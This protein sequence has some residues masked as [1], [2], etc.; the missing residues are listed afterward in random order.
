MPSECYWRTYYSASPRSAEVRD[1]SIPSVPSASPVAPPSFNIESSNHEG[2]QSDADKRQPAAVVT[3]EVP[4]ETEPQIVGQENGFPE[5]DSTAPQAPITTT[6]TDIASVSV[7]QP[8]TPRQSG[9][10]ETGEAVVMPP[11]LSPRHQLL[12][13]EHQRVMVVIV[14][15][16]ELTGSLFEETSLNR[17]IK[18]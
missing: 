18:A 12:R 16:I 6:Q 2:D 9:Q 17:I 4:P 5:R 7:N 15:V 10:P 1:T 13:P 14:V 8:G 3:E 11:E